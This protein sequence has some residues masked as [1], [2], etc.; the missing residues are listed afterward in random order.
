MSVQMKR[1]RECVHRDGEAAGRFYQGTAYVESLQRLPVST[2]MSVARNVT[3]FFWSD[4]AHIVVW[5]CRDCASHLGLEPSQ[6]TS[7][8]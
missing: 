1:E 2:A 4:A 8:V 5:L 6:D 3:A 7:I